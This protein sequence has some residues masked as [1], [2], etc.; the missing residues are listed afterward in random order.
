MNRFDPLRKLMHVDEAVAR[1]AAQP[2]TVFTHGSFDVLHRGQIAFLAEARQLGDR[3]VVAV[4]NDTV[5]GAN[6]AQAGRPL[7]REGDRAFQVAALE[8]VDAVVISSDPSPI[9]LLMRLK[10]SVYVQ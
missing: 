3:L 4:E 10:P 7:N 2:G 5:A 8:S 1:F 9:A 6:A